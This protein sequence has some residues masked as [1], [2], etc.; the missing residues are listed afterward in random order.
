MTQI[1]RTFIAIAAGAAL[2][3]GLGSIAFAQ[4][5][6]VTDAVRNGVVGETSAGYLGFAQTPSGELRAQV[7]AIN[8][9][10]RARYSELAQE[11]GATRARVAFETACRVLAGLDQG[12]AYQL[13]DGVWRTVGA[14]GVQLPP[15]CP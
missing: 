10:R 4:S 1:Y 11:S 3:A 14:G 7:D 15:N 2:L 9:R 8:L 12:R 6:I 5:S 13:E